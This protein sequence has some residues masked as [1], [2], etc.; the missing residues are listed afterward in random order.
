MYVA[1]RAKFTQHKDLQQML[2]DTKD[3]WLVEHTKNDKQWADG[4]TGEGTNFL[5]KL[6]MQLREE[7]NNNLNENTSLQDVIDNCNFNFE[8]LRSPM[9]KFLEYPLPA[10]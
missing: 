3:S 10:N 7:L 8:Y 2:L 9:N 4:L 6:L 5:G 1:L